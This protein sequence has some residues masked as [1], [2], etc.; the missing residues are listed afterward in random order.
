VYVGT[1]LQ[2]PDDPPLRDQLG[3]G[4]VDGEDAV[5]VRRQ[6]QQHTIRD[7]GSNI[8]SVTLGQT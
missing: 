7:L 2:G 8:A 3:V 1:L 4:D 6:P 5:A